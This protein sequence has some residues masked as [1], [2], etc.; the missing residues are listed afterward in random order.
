MRTVLIIGG[1][2]VSLSVAI[3]AGGESKPASRIN[4]QPQ[5]MR[6]PPKPLS[7]AELRSLGGTITREEQLAAVRSNPAMNKLLQR[8][9]SG[10]AAFPTY[11]DAWSKGITLTPLA[12]VYPPDADETNC[13]LY[14]ETEAGHFQG[15]RKPLPHPGQNPPLLW[16]RQIDKNKPLVRIWAHWPTP[17]GYLITF[18]IKDRS[19]NSRGAPRVRVGDSYQTAV[20]LNPLSGDRWTI[21]WNGI[22]LHPRILEPVDLHPGAIEYDFLSCCLSKVVIRKLN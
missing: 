17:G 22:Q 7:D 13:Q 15:V 19:P 4:P 6:S 12:G 20:P 8:L 10:K 18:F 1:L 2:V 9:G 5:D 3:T 14:L 16:L 11:S 21:L